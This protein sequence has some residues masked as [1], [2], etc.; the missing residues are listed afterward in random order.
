[1]ASRPWGFCCICGG[2]PFITSSDSPTA[3]DEPCPIYDALPQALI[4]SDVARLWIKT[5][6]R[7]VQLTAC[8]WKAILFL[9]CVPQGLLFSTRH[10]ASRSQKY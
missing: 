9:R 10:Y 3:W 7:P 4:D 1:M 8:Q 2:C 5:S 6:K